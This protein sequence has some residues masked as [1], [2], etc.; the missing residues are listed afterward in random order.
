MTTLIIRGVE[1]QIDFKEDTHEYFVNGDKV[2][3]VSN[4]L[5]DVLSNNEP[6]PE[7]AM[8]AVKRGVLFHKIISLDLLGGVEVE[9]IDEKLKGYWESYSLFKEEHVLVPKHIEQVMYNPIE[10]ICMTLDYGGLYD[11][12]RSLLD[13]KTG[14]M[15]AK[16]KAQLGGYYRGALECFGYIPEIIL[17][18]QLFK[19]GKI[20]KPHIFEIS[21]CTQRWDSIYNVYGYKREK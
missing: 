10:N 1:Y 3:C 20:A 11:T 6:I 19:N 9:S 7:Y 4:I 8:P 15:Y 5:S 16:Y 14:G 13:W 2:P 21:E 17:D 12:A 18:V